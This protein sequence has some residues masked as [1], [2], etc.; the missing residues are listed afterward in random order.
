M[1][2]DCTKNKADSPKKIN[3]YMGLRRRSCERAR[4]NQEKRVKDASVN[5]RNKYQ[6]NVTDAFLVNIESNILNFDTVNDTAKIRYA[7][8]I[9]AIKLFL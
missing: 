7:N 8:I 3:F 2:A 1:Q 9:N 6:L 4:K 5:T